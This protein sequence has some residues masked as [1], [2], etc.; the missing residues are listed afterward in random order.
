VFSASGRSTGSAI[1]TLNC[2][3]KETS[4]VWGANAWQAHWAQSNHASKRTIIKTP[5]PAGT[6]TVLYEPAAA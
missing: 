5:L 3:T 4:P 2:Y 6:V 1:Q